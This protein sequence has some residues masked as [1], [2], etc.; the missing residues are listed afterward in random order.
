[1]SMKGFILC[2][3]KESDLK[4]KKNYSVLRLVEAAEKAGHTL[5]VLTPEQFELV[6]TRSD[7]KSILIDGISQP[8]PDFIIPRM[9]SETTYFGLAVIR[10]L[11]HL[12][13]YSCNTSSSI[14]AVKDKLH[15]HQILAQSNLPTPKTMM[16]KF[17]ADIEA[18]K[19]EIGFPIVVKN[20]VGARGNG[21]YLSDSE[22]RFLDLMHL[23]YSHNQQAN[24]ILQEFVAP[25]SGKDLRVFILGGE[26][27][28]CMMRKSKSGFKANYSLGGTVEPYDLPEEAKWLA[29]ETARLMKLEIAGIDLLFDN[30]GFKICEANSSPGFEG[31]EQVAGRHVAEDIINYITTKLEHTRT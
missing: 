27:V 18:V 21:I 17:P 19:R 31:L 4:P 24:I 26:V 29:K 2:K 15:V 6:V 5:K 20:I 3:T 8:L 7:R 16:L 9:G 28:A 22:D 1:M 12:G 25:S 30:G 11:E 23:I 14:E 13:V 10:Q